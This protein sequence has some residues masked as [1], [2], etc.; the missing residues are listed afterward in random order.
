PEAA[1]VL[2]PFIGSVWEAKGETDRAM[3]LYRSVE[4]KAPMEVRAR[5]A[6][7]LA[8]T[9]KRQEALAALHQLENPAP[10]APPPN[11]FDIGVIYGTLGD[12]DQAFAWL[13]KAYEDRNVWF[14]KVH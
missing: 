7:L 4:P 10:D 13:E 11:A 9:G 8:A 14:L 2:Q 12:R 3:A 1:V 5:I 6:H